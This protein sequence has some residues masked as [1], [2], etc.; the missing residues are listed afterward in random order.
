[1]SSTLLLKYGKPTEQ[2]IKKIKDAWYQLFH[3][4]K[5]FVT[6]D[7][8]YSSVSDYHGELVVRRNC[9]DT[10]W[11]IRYLLSWSRRIEIHE[12]KPVRKQIVDWEFV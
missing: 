7:G 11:L 12:V 8:S 1:M 5:W 6:T 2:D 3:T 9:D 4:R 10:Y